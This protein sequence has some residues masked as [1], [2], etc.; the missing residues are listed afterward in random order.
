[1]LASTVSFTEMSSGPRN[2][3]AFLQ[4]SQDLRS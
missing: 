4:V 3:R 2:P 1:L